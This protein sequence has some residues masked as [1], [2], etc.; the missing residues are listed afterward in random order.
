MIR[1]PPRS[2]LFPYTTLF[3]SL[4]GA[5]LLVRCRTGLPGRRP[6]RRS[7]ARR[8]LAE[9]QVVLDLRHARWH[10]PW[11]V[12]PG[13]AHEPREPGEERWVTSCAAAATFVAEA[14]RC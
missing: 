8:H 4:P 5:R 1:R 11:S 6:G 9:V 13:S 12:R 2:T 3:R 14:G 7:H 10:H